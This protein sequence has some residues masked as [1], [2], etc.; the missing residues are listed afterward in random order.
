[1]AR[2][3]DCQGVYSNPPLARRLSSGCRMNAAGTVPS[4][5]EVAAHA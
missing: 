2:G 3:L 5:W 4:N 1:M